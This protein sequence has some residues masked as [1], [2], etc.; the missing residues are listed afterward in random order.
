MA[1]PYVPRTRLNG[2]ANAGT[3]G[4]WYGGGTVPFSPSDIA[5][6]KAWY[7]ASDTSSI[8][9]SSTAVTQW[10]DK[11]GNAYHLTQATAAKRPTSGTRTQ[12]GLNAIDFD[13]AGD[14]VA[15]S[16]AA[17]WAFL[18]NTG[19][20]TYFI[21]WFTD[22]ASDQ[23]IFMDTNGTSSGNVGI[24]NYIWT[25]DTILCSVSSISSTQPYVQV[26][27]QVPTDNTAS[28][29]S[30]LSDPNNGTAANRI[31]IWKNG[32]NPINSNTNTAT[33]SANSPLTGL[34][35]GGN[36]SYAET[37]DG[38]ICEV[39]FYSGLLS[40]TDRQKVETYL[41]VKWGI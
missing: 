37:F 19:G 10:N 26:T 11:S 9:V 29:W 8:T 6:L 27:S 34:N 7:D 16:T 41:A 3:I 31:K 30:F 33:P 15:A 1:R 13:G 12:N 22:T 39:I 28:Y 32:A 25:D 18:N 17:N 2:S 20:S 40:D 23:R 5:N 24:Y 21:V 4:F 35:L 36:P 14:T 38:L